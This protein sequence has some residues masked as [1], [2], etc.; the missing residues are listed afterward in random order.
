V[1]VTVTEVNDPPVATADSA[2][3]AEDTALGM[4]ASAL[5]SNDSPGPAN[6]SGQSLAVTSVSPTSAQGGTVVLSGDAIS[7]SPPVNFFG[8]DSFS[9]TVSDDG[10]TN[11]TADAMSVVGEVMVTVTEVNDVPLCTGLGLTTP[12]DTV[13]SRDLAPQCSDVDGDTL[14]IEL[15]SLSLQGTSTLAGTVL[16]YTPNGDFNGTDSVTFRARDGSTFSNTAT[17]NI[18]VS[19]VNDAPIANA[20]PDQTVDEGGTVTLAGSGSD[21]DGDTLTF[22]WAQTAGPAVTLTNASSATASFTAPQVDVD[23]VLTFQ[24]TVNDGNSGTTSDTVNVTVRNTTPTTF[25]PARTIGYWKNHPDQLA[26]ILSQ[27]SINL[28]DTMVTTV[29]QAV[30]T[31]SNADAKDARNSLRAQLLAAILNLKNGADPN[32]TGTDIRPTVDASINFLA[33]NNSPVDGKHPN[34]QQALALKDNL[35]AYNNSGERLRD[36]DDRDDDDDDDRENGGDK[37][38]GKD[39]KGKD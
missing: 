2:T 12:E 19:P 38:S 8:T 15:V 18:T 6:E 36:D 25:Q 21:V 31:L 10:T 14:A 5:L 16:T 11:G 32:A 24:I 30:A 3:T 1:M 33:T 34:R 20:G 13:V 27:G 39:K 37:K 23:T 17:V 26:A 28:G 35:D 22:Q 7:Y 29:S 9:Y 4:A